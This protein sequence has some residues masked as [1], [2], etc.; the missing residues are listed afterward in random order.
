[1]KFAKVLSKFKYVGVAALGYFGNKYVSDDW[2][3]DAE[4][5]LPQTLK[6]KLYPLLGLEFKMKYEDMTEIQHLYVLKTLKF[7]EKGKYL[8]YI[9]D[10]N[11]SDNF[12]VKICSSDN[13]YNKNYGA[14]AEPPNVFTEN[15]DMLPKSN[16]F[17]WTL[18]KSNPRY[19]DLVDDP[20][21]N[22]CLYVIDKLGFYGLDK[23]KKELHTEKLY[24]CA[25]N[26]GKSNL[27]V[28]VGDIK[29][30]TQNIIRSID[31]EDPELFRCV[32][33]TKTDNFKEELLKYNPKYKKYINDS[34]A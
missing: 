19:I 31:I 26:S 24:L 7:A 8:E 6:L 32:N 29:H 2:S 22:M 25:I 12:F 30:W 21:E 1:M 17:K 18:I 33:A 13:F 15:K 4:K 10:Q 27:E 34:V 9:K 28:C 3:F 16:Y 23:I 14:D 20:T 11:L 5:N